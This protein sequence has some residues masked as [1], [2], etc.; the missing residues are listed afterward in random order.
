MI[1]KGK[2]EIHLKIFAE[3]KQEGFFIKSYFSENGQNK[4]GLL[5][6]GGVIKV[7]TDGIK[8]QILNQNLMPVMVLR[9]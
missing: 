7:T 4:G 6:R 5:I 8:D 2:A 1:S 3:P 9:A